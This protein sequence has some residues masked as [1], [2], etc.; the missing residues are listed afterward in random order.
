MVSAKGRELPRITMV[1]TFLSG[2]LV[3]E[4]SF[5]RAANDAF[6]TWEGLTKIAVENSDP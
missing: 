4:R 1:L 6:S 2:D 3:T 5:L